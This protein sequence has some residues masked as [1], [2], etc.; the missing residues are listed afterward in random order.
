MTSA[1]LTPS[2]VWKTN[3]ESVYSDVYKTDQ[4][5]YAQAMASGI[6]PPQAQD[7]EFSGDPLQDTFYSLYKRITTEKTP[8]D[9]HLTPLA[10]ILNRAKTLPEYQNLRTSTVGNKV[11]AAIAAHTFG[12]ALMRNIPDDIK[13]RAYF[14]GSYVNMS[15]AIYMIL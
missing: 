9:A 11:S 12:A 13:I 15:Q 5:N 10:D 2:D 7:F 4:M 6:V 3:I 1:P 8:Q 14:S